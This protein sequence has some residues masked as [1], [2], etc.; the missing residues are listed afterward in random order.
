MKALKRNYETYASLEEELAALEKGKKA[1]GQKN[2][3]LSAFAKHKVIVAELLDRLSE[4]DLNL[5]ENISRLLLNSTFE[6]DQ[7]IEA[8]DQ[9]KEEI[10]R[11]IPVDSSMVSAVGYDD[12]NDILYVEF[13][14]TGNIYAYHNVPL[15]VFD[16]MLKSS[17]IGNYVRNE[18]ISTYAYEKV[19]KDNL[20][21]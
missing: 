8:L 17:S 9:K 20:K 18:I 15:K 3:L 10:L 4:K 1:K 13:L 19:K 14:D 5:S 12:E 21:W 7:L 2:L 6:L 16:G 11:R